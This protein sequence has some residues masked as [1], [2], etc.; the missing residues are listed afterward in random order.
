MVRALDASL[1]T[2]S[3][4]RTHWLV[5]LFALVTGGIHVYAGLVEGRTP[6]LLAGVGFF[7][8]VVLFLVDYRRS[9]LYVLGIVYT[10]VQLPLWYV[11]KAGEYTTL[12]Y[13]DK[14]IQ[15]ILIVLLVYLYW[16]TRMATGT[17]RESPT[18]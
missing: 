8:A 10:A 6:V 17:D 7:G 14:L 3:L 18:I 9:L 12:G 11:V 5:V 15:V 4:S 16:N 13:A 2:G 1:E